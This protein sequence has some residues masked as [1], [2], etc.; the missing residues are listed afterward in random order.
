MG[1]NIWMICKIIPSYV[2]SRMGLTTET[3]IIIL[4]KFKTFKQYHPQYSIML[5]LRE[6][7]FYAMN[8]GLN[9]KDCYLFIYI[10]Y[11]D[12]FFLHEPQSHLPI[13]RLL[14]ELLP[15]CIHSMPCHPIP[16]QLVPSFFLTTRLRFTS[17]LLTK[18]LP[19]HSTPTTN[20]EV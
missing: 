12:C 1:S 14:A 19:S 20:A 9:Q 8:F 17:P 15:T 18:S 16:T 7:C 11:G 13:Y 10:P 3:T 2:T 6:Q 4:S 5:C